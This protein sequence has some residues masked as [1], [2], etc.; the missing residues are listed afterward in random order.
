MAD[1]KDMSKSAVAVLALSAVTLTALAIVSGFKNSGALGQGVEGN[2]TNATADA[3]IAGLAIFGTF[4]VVIVLALVGKI[5]VS[6][7]K[8]SK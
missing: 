1:V 2:A 3:F 8:T 7:F 5:I 4:M 6:L